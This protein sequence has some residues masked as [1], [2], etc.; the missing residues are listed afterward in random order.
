MPMYVR[1]SGAR[2]RLF[3]FGEAKVDAPK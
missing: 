1:V 3:G 2:G